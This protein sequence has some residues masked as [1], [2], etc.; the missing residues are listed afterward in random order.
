LSTT[1]TA[2]T[3]PPT[4]TAPIHDPVA[5]GHNAAGEKVSGQLPDAGASDGGAAGP[6]VVG[7]GLVAL[8]AVGGGVTAWRRRASRG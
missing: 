8:L 6:A 3:S 2:G 4:V 7:V 5:V 1:P